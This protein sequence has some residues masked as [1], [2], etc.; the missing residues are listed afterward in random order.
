MKRDLDLI[1]KMVLAIEDAPSAWAPA[2]LTFDGY[3]Q[4]QI[5]YHSWLLVNAGLALGDDATT[6]DAECPAAFLLNLTW[7]GHEF[8]AACRDEHRWTNA[9]K[10]VGTKAGDVTFAVLSRLLADLMTRAL[11]P[12]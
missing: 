2:Q 7:A 5:D 11:I 8:A 6:D 3:S 1:R 4:V 10:T 9:M 12:S